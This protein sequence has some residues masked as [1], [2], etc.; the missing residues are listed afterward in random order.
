VSKDKDVFGPNSELVRGRLSSLCG[1]FVRTGVDEETFGSDRILK[2]RVAN[3]YWRYSMGFDLNSACHVNDT[4]V[5]L[6][7]WGY[8]QT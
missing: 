4:G 7:L 2:R 6:L 1:L 5:G 8:G 3:E